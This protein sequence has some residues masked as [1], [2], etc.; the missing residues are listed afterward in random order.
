[1]SGMYALPLCVPINRAYRGVEF[2]SLHALCACGICFFNPDVFDKSMKSL[3]DKNN[4]TATFTDR[5]ENI[6]GLFQN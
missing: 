5:L 2:A 1:M 6:I 4:L 3:A